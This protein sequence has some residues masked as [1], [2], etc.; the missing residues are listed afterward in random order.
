MCEVGGYVVLTLCFGVIFLN[1]GFIG[2][3]NFELNHYH[4]GGCVRLEGMLYLHCALGLFFK[5]LVSSE[6]VTSSCVN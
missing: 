4:I 2:G 6:G 5:I 3:G 1:P